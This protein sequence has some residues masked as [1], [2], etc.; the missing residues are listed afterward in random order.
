MIGCIVSALPAVVQPIRN[1]FAA[2][3]DSVSKYRDNV[4]YYDDTLVNFKEFSLPKPNLL[5]AY[6]TDPAAVA[7][8]Q[9]KKWDMVYIDGNHD[10]EVA[11]KDW[12]VCSAATRTGGIIVL[13]DSALATSYRPPIFATGI[14]SRALMLAAPCCPCSTHTCRI[15]I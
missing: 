9:S 15:A 8:I 2:I 4:D 13:D 10:Y 14:S 11:R 5:K 7:L 12:D 1:A 6:S 3:G